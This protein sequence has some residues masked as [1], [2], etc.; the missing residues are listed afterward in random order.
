LAWCAKP[1]CPNTAAE[2]IEAGLFQLLAMAA[3]DLSMLDEEYL[4][5]ASAHASFR[6][7]I[8]LRV[9]PQMPPFQSKEP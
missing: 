3:I 7:A 8:H 2:I 4:L 9:L 5:A 1:K 6:S